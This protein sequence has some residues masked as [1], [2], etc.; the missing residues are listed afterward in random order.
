[1]M[2]KITRIV[3]TPGMVWYE[4]A[5]AG[6]F[7]TGRADDM[8]TDD[9]SVREYLEECLRA[10]IAYLEGHWSPGKSSLLRIPF[11]RLH[12]EDGDLKLHLPIRD[13]LKHILRL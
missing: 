12:T 9:T 1:M 6:G 13:E 2:P 10:A 5:V 4:L 8:A 3:S 7:G 11:V